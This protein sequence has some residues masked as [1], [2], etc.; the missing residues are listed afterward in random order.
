MD[1]KSAAKP[2][3]LLSMRANLKPPDLF[4]PTVAGV[5]KVS[6]AVTEPPISSVCGLKVPCKPRPDVPETRPSPFA[7]ISTELPLVELDDHQLASNE[8]V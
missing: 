1:N 2:A 3:S 7:S 4:V 8:P 6:V 5:V